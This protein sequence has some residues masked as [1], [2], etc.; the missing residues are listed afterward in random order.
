MAFGCH[1]QCGVFHQGLW[2]QITVWVLVGAPL[3]MHTQSTLIGELPPSSRC[4]CQ[5]WLKMNPSLGNRVAYSNR[6]VC[7]PPG[8]VSPAKERR[9]VWPPSGGARDIMEVLNS[10]VG[11]D[12]SKSCPWEYGMV[13]AEVLGS[14]HSLQVGLLLPNE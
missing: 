10:T 4:Y 11:G 7:S 12:R 1:F 9:E 3:P 8:G 13:Q 6:T 2:M 14:G 5:W